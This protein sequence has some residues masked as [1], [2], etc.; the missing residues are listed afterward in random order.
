M[1]DK[2]LLR[3]VRVRVAASVTSAIIISILGVRYWPDLVQRSEYANTS[4]VSRK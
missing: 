4:V 2:F 3:D 1:V